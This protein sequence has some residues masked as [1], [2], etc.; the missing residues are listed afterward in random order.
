MEKSQLRGT[1]RENSVIPR[2]V[3]VHTITDLLENESS[4][5]LN[6]S[7]LIEVSRSG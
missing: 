6:V 2:A 5:K 7:R 3:D 4:P 1:A